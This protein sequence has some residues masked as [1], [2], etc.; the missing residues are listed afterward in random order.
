MLR[1]ITL[2]RIGGELPDSSALAEAMQAQ[3]YVP[4]T[5]TQA[6]SLGW[7]PPRGRD[8]GA[9]LECIDGHWIAM[10]AI[11]KRNVP[12]QAI[13][14]RVA[15]LCDA[16]DKETGRRPKG[17]ALRDLKD[18]AVHELRPRAFP[19][20]VNVLVWIDPK[21]GTVAIDASSASRA[22]AAASLLIASAP[23]TNLH[24]LRTAIAPESAMTGWVNSV[25]PPA[26]FELGRDAELRGFAEQPPVV[27]VSRMGLDSDE[28]MAHVT[29]GGKQVVKL[30]MTHDGKTEFTLWGNGQLRG[31]T[32]SVEMAKGKGEDDPF[33]ANV[34][35][36][37][38][39]LAPMLAHLL[40]SL[41]GVMALPIESAAE[42]KGGQ[43]DRQP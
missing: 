38:G 11:E 37:T 43:D 5:P 4:G 32:L 31:V 34:A 7:V 20:R 36:T 28:V 23:L 33:D 26:W 13:K 30:A 1:N 18:R 25:E 42:N 14:A 19:R 8:H 39:E 3:A 29:D 22:E 27:K 6:V 35:L 12:T 15:E 10:A 24:P 16:I 41:G 40:E 2:Y 21:A 9:L 17:K